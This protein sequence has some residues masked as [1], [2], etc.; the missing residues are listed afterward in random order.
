MS[1][2]SERITTS[3]STIRKINHEDFTQ[4]L[5]DFKAKI[6][7]LKLQDEYSSVLETVEKAHARN[8]LF[9]QFS[10]KELAE[11]TRDKQEI[12]DQAESL[13]R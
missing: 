7:F 6:Y 12:S 1:T 3:L 9:K 8:A 2:I 5:I 11:L 13:S 10:Q 4:E